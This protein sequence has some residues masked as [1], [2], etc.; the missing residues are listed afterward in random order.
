MSLAIFRVMLRGLIRDPGA[1]ALTFVVPA[2][3]FLV[4]ASV[5]AASSGG[6]FRP[7][8]ERTGGRRC[9]PPLLLRPPWQARHPAATRA[10]H[11]RRRA[12][13][14]RGRRTAC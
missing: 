4:F 3:F 9:S 10:R 13:Q 2:V 14:T 12:R 6:N 5:F 11:D 7:R 1:L 8:I